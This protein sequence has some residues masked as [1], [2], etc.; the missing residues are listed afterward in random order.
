MAHYSRIHIPDGGGNR[1]GL[2]GG[3]GGIRL[4]D[5]QVNLPHYM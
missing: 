4:K 3:R 1:H 2:A 5:Q